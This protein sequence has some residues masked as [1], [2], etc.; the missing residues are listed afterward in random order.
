MT[1][2]MTFRAWIYM[3]D[4][5][6]N[7]AI[8]SKW[9][10]ATQGGWILRVAASTSDR[11]DV[12]IA[13]TLG[14]SGTGC[15]MQTSNLG[16]SAATWYQVVL[17]FD[18]S[19]TGDTNRVKLYLNGA[20]TTLTTTSGGVPS[21]LQDNTADLSIGKLPGLDLYFNGREDEI[22][23]GNVAWSAAQVTAD[24]NAGAGVFY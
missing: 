10:Y 3:T 1:A 4:L 17:V 20:A 15:S 23:L 6:T 2:K 13:T 14:D 12:F 19:L 11:M 8:A 9:L 18:G 16:W 24:F 5:G 21:A 22:L 7:R